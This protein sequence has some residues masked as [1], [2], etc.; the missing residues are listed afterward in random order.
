MPKIASSPARSSTFLD[1]TAS[2][3]IIFQLLLGLS[4]TPFASQNGSQNT[5]NVRDAYGEHINATAMH[6]SQHAIENPPNDE[7]SHQDFAGFMGNADHSNSDVNAMP[8]QNGYAKSDP[9]HFF[10]AEEIKNIYSGS[11]ANSKYELL[12]NDFEGGKNRVSNYSES[13]GDPIVSKDI[14][15]AFVGRRGENE[16]QTVSIGPGCEHVGVIIHEL[17]HALGFWHEQSR[18]DRDGYVEILE[19]N[20]VP[21]MR[22]NFAKMH[23]TQ[24]NS[25]GEPYD[26]DSIMHYRRNDFAIAPNYETIRPLICCPYPE[27]GQRLELS[28]GDIRQANLLYSCPACGRTLLEDSGTIASPEANEAESGF[29]QQEAKP[30]SHPVSNRQKYANSVSNDHK[31][32][33]R[34]MYENKFPSMSEASTSSRDSTNRIFCQWR[35][36]AAKGE[37]IHLTFTHMDMLPPAFRSHK[38]TRTPN[39]SHNCTKQYVQVRD[40]YSSGSPLIVY[41]GDYLKSDEGSFNSP[42]YPDVYLPSRQCIWRIKV[43]DGY[44]VELTFNSFEIVLSNWIVAKPRITVV[45]TTA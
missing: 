32:I 24:V 34:I 19:E 1:L 39:N 38:K 16:P 6:A 37:R 23:P 41:C 15:C 45:N 33:E 10:N 26:F 30:A 7:D 17:G 2:V 18:P 14:C 11:D 21:Q 31:S 43:T 4:T 5:Q 42:G 25:L 12:Q 8:A 40:G 9:A 44:L 13:P 20:I 22:F 29:R 28:H 35:I 3:V 27:F 36:V